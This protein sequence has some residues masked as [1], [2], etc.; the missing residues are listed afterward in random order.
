MSPLSLERRGLEMT[1]GTVHNI[2]WKH[3][4]KLC[5]NDGHE[6]K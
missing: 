6:T 3:I 5:S 2:S 1:L 4:P